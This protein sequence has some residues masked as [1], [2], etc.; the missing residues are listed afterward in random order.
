VSHP[1]T[2]GRQRTY[3]AA[4]VL[5]YLDAD[6]LGLAKILVQLRND[7]TYPGDPGGVLH[8]RRRLACPVERT[9]VP[10]RLWI[11]EVT[12]RDWLISLGT[13]T[14]L[15]TV[16]KSKPCATATL[17]WSPLPVGTRSEHGTNSKFS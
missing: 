5:F 7:V 13:A 14:S 10:D 11:P 16:Q 17:G 8:K 1:A 12:S 9:D 3:P 4:T 2:P 15:S 6:V